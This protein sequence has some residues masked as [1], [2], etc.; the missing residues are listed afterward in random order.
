MIV[1][2]VATGRDGTRSIHMTTCRFET[3]ANRFGRSRHVVPDLNKTNRTIPHFIFYVE[4][5]SGSTYRVAEVKFVV[6]LVRVCNW[7]R[8]GRLFHHRDAALKSRQ[9][10][11]Q[12]YIC[13]VVHRMRPHGRIWVQTGSAADMHSLTDFD[14]STCL[15]IGA[16]H[17]VN[18]IIIVFCTWLCQI[19]FTHSF[20]A[21][22]SNCCHSVNSQW[23]WLK[24]KFC[25]LLY[26][27]L[28]H[29]T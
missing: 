8:H 3:G 2:I 1:Y 7:A 6:V 28:V 19:G 21:T 18:E 15:V 22:D 24:L 17:V 4:S 16:S 27:T 10:P 9:H 26:V 23:I 20:R 14:R 25:I 12:E 11:R 13:N 29:T 5:A